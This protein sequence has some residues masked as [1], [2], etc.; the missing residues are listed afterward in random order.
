M[1]RNSNRQLS[2]ESL[3]RV[4]VVKPGSERNFGLVMAGFFALLAGIAAWR[5][6]LVWTAGWAAVS[7]GFGAA[8][9][10]APRVLAP[11]NVAW[12]RFGMILHAVINPLIMGAMFFVI[13]APIGIIM[14]ILGKR[15]IPLRPDRAAASYWRSRSEQPGP[16]SKQY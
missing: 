3:S 1:G 4:E 9:L 11:L 6:A 5:L 2:G 8:A 13:I 10:L 16:M 12:F 7:L 15:P 14:R